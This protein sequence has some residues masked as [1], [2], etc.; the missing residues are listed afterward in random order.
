M[1]RARSG[2]L[3][4]REIEVQREEIEMEGVKQQGPEDD[5]VR[6]LRAGFWLERWLDRVPAF[7]TTAL[8]GDRNGEEM[9]M[10]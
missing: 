4:I 6:G 3:E 5:Q 9:E 10:E 7:N 1:K 8:G 2:D